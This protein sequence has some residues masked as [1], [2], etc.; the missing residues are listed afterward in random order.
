MLF[1][2][3]IYFFRFLL[4]YDGRY[5]PHDAHVLRRFRR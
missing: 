1:I 4:F 3:Y 2:F 5:V